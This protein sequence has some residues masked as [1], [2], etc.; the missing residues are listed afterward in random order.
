MSAGPPHSSLRIKQGNLTFNS[1]RRDL[2]LSNAAEDD[3]SDSEEDADRASGSVASESLRS[4]IAVTR[5]HLTL[6]RGSGW[7]IVTARVGPS[8]S[9]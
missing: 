3:K 7:W 6:A 4:S 1:P 2:V 5:N 9:P 8:L